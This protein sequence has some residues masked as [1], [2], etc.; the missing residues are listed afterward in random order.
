MPRRNWTRQETLMALAFYLCPPLPRKNWDDSDAEVQLLA[1]KIGRSESAVC[2][3]I[4][5]LK[6]CDPN[7]SGSGFAHAAT[8]DAQVMAEYLSEPD[9][10]MSEALCELEQTGIQISY[11][12]RIEVPGPSRL[13]RPQKFGVER[14]TQIRTRV[15]QDYFRNVLLANYDSTCCL[16]GVSVPALLTASHIKPWAA[17]TQSERLMSSN[18]LLLN[19]FHDRAFDRGLIT[20]DN[21]Y[22][23]VV[24]SRVPHTPANDRWIYAY[25]DNRIRLPRG[26]ESTWPSLE[27]I[28]YHNDCVF[29]R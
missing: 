23:I 8:M 2:L 11:D 6:A 28:R 15:N 22:R 27:F 25:A 7:R 19:A 16:T 29:E 4:G 5:N 10:T 26:G 3:K 20:L 17:A 18:G 1:E 14:T 12:G 9:E 24:S 13:G 21:R